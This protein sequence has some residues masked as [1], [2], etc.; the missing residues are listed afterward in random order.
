M[1]NKRYPVRLGLMLVLLLLLI[2]PG[3]SFL[4]RGVHASPRKLVEAYMDA[5]QAGDFEMMLELSGGW[6]GSP[7]ELEFHRS[8]AEMIE[9]KSY[10]ID[11]IEQ[12]S[13]SEAVVDVTVVLALLGQEKTEAARIRVVKTDGIWLLDEG[14]LK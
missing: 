12:V 5:F 8:F 14:F 2:A 11:N 7:E 4:Q 10:S 9:L 1:L 6:E 13:G 3:C